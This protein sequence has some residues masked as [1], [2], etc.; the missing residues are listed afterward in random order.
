MTH[1]TW[2]AKEYSDWVAALQESTVHNFKGHP[3]VKRMLGEVDGSLY[4]AY[5]GTKLPLLRQIDAIGGSIPGQLE[6]FIYYAKMVLA[7]KPTAI[8][9][10]GG[11]CG[12]FYAILRALGYNGGYYIYDLKGAQEFQA[13]YLYEVFK[14][15]GL[16]G[17]LYLYQQ[18]DFC[19]S[20][21]ALG[22]FDDYIKQYYIDNVVK[23]CPHGLVVWNPHSGASDNITWPCKVEP[24]VPLT[25]P[26]NKLL[27]W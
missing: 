11:G 27:T 7:K 3:Q 14:Q 2:L 18:F 25:S 4:P 15:T 20:L 19:V 21:Y 9:E 12:E 16:K 8:C 17:N 5:M 6:R 24:E 1:S 10:I 23:K 13:D 22:E 26:N